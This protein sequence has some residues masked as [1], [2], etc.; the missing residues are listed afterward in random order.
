MEINPIPGLLYED[1]ETR[2]KIFSDLKEISAIAK[3]LKSETR[4]KILAI[5]RREE[6]DVSRLAKRLNQTEANI[7][8]QIQNLQKVGLVSS[9][10]EPGAHGVRKIC[11]VTT[12]RIIIN[13]E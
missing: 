6:L 12:D 5:L 4:Q 13:L 11:S 8:A 2:T 1:R 7:S 10:Y 3:A 9:K